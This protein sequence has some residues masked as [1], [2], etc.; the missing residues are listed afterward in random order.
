[1]KNY[2]IEVDGQ[3]YQVKVRPLPDDADMQKTPQE[4]SSQKNTMPP[5]PSNQAEGR[6]ITSPMSGTIVKV[7]VQEGQKVKEGEVLLVLEAMKMENEVVAPTGGTIQAV[8]V[9]ANDSVASDQ[10]MLI[11]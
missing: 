2:E 3:V 6:E 8:L 1:M 9:K 10:T 7:L 11:M 5:A 4:A